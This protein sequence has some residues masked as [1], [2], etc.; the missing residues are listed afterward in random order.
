[1]AD[2]NPVADIAAQP[3]EMLHAVWFSVLKPGL[4][5]LP[6]GQPGFEHV[7]QAQTLAEATAA[8]R[9]I[10]GGLIVANLVVFVNP[11]GTAA[12]L[13]RPGGPLRN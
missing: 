6:N 4:V 3:G 12:G 8:V 13:V 10:A 2:P 7:H 1:M 9:P 5:A 11:K